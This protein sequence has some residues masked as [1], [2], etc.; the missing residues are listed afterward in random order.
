MQSGLVN[1]AEKYINKSLEYDPENLYTELLRAYIPFARNRDLEQTKE[2]LIKALNRDSSSYDI[3]KEI[4]LICYY[5]RDYESAYTYFN[6]I[7]EI[8]NAQ[9]LDI[10][11]GENAKIGVVLSEVGL[12]E[13]SD[14]YFNDF[15]DFAENDNSIYKNLSLAVYYSYKGDTEKAIDN[16]KLFSEQDNYPYWYIL[17]IGIDPLFDNIKDTPEFRKILNDIE[18]KF[19]KR[20]KKIKASLE[21]KNLL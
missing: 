11:R 7:T 12:A 1:E 3:N 8:R 17:F 2:L 19:W 5:M 10:D 16:M 6:K 15:L 9:N 4:G 20:Q 14:N 13:E 21:A 18:V